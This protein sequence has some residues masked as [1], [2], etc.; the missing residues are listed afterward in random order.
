MGCSGRKWRLAT[1]KHTK[2]SDYL[3]QVYIVFFL[4]FKTL[5]FTHT[6]LSLSH[7]FY[8]QYSR[9]S[10]CNLTQLTLKVT[11]PQGIRFCNT[12]WE[13]L[14]KDRQRHKLPLWTGPVRWRSSA[15]REAPSNQTLNRRKSGIALRQ[16]SEK[17]LLLITG[18]V[19]LQ[20]FNHICTSWVNKHLQITLITEYKHIDIHVQVV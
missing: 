17:S 7:H 19:F 8:S 20:R 16:L 5:S 1:W 3:S 4:T 11:I 15:P 6:T 18:Y 12:V 13:C 2:G 10:P 14:L 9:L